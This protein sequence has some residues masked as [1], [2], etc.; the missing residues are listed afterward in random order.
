MKIWKNLLKIAEK[1]VENCWKKLLKIWKKLLKI[2]KKLLTNFIDNFG[3][4]F[5]RE[6]LAQ[7]A[8]PEDGSTGRMSDLR[9]VRFLAI[10][11]GILYGA[12]ISASYKTRPQRCTHQ[13]N[14]QPNK[15]TNKQKNTA[16][17]NNI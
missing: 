15:Q 3:K 9:H 1:I 8:L 17:N 5:Q 11:F 2:W 4:I 14:N 12:A 7:T 13:T 16:C 6:N 10:S